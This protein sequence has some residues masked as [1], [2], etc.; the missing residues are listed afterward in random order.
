MDSNKFSNWLQVAGNFG[1]LAGLILVGFQINQNTE[2]AR[3][4]LTA[5]SFEL[6]MQMNL[7]RM[8]ENPEAALAKAATDPESLTD[9]ELGIVAQWVFFWGDYDRRFDLLRDQGL[10]VQEIDWDVFYKNRA[11]WVYGV[12]RVT[13]ETWKD[14]NSLGASLGSD[15][16]STVDAEIQKIDQPTA[17]LEF[18][19]RMRAA[20]KGN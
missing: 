3:T 13:L 16:E 4:G 9:E 11:N 20:A 19:E 18:L 10:V 8:G 12:N 14:I 6:A 7:A 5:R 1:L 2:I 15:W 17:A